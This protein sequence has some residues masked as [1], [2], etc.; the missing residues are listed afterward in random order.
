MQPEID[1][2]LL[3][4]QP[5]IPESAGVEEH[6][7]RIFQLIDLAKPDHII[8]DAI[9]ACQ[10]MGTDTM[11]FDFLVRLL[12]YCKTEGIT[13]IYLNQI[14]SENPVDEISGIGISSLVDSLI[15]LEQ[16]WPEKS[17]QRRLLITKMRGSSHSHIYHDF[18]ITDKGVLI[19]ETPNLQSDSYNKQS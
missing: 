18:S 10:R 12:T 16:L 7:W 8:I 6:L 2:Q 17:H 14:G 1:S 4:I 9:S 5:M 19:H 11:A 3:N 13:C 15:V